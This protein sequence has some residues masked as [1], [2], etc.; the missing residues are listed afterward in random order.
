MCTSVVGAC[1]LRLPARGGRGGPGL[2]RVCAGTC[3]DAHARRSTPGSRRPVARLA[4]VAIA[5]SVAH[6]V[7]ADPS[8]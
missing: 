7:A 4:R 3:H 8:A 6:R 1:V 2:A 5:M